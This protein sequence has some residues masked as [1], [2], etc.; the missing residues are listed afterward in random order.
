MPSYIFRNR[1]NKIVRGKTS[2][3][4]EDCLFDKIDEQADPYA[5]EYC[6]L[7]R[8]TVW[9]DEQPVWLMFTTDNQLVQAVDS[10]KEIADSLYKKLSEPKFDAYTCFIM[11]RHEL[12]VYNLDAALMRIRVDLD[13]L[14]SL[15]KKLYDYIQFL[16]R[17]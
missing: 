13:K 10:T 5:F 3:K 1:Y 11:A 2:V 4:S 14:I 15:D 7:S 9:L 6:K 8:N 16:I 17:N 12:A